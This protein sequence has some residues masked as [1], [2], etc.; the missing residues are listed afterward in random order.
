VIPADAKRNLLVTLAGRGASVGLNFMATV[1]VIRYLGPDRYGVY[2]LVVTIVTLLDQAAEVPLFEIAVREMAKSGERAPDWL[3]AVALVRGASGLA[4]GAALLAA[5]PL[6]G[7]DASMAAAAHAGALVF[8]ANAFRAPVTYFRSQLQIHWEL[9]LWAAARALEFGLVVLAS[10]AGL[11]VE[12]MIGAKALAAVAF[13][14][15]AWS[16]LLWRFRLSP[17]AG[18]GAVGPLCA[19]ALPVAVTA[20]LMLLQVKGDVLLI[21]F[22]LGPAAAGSFGAVAQIPEFVLV[23]NSVLS[24]TSGPLLARTLGRGDTGQFQALFQRLFDGLAAVLPGLATVACLAAGPCVSAVFGERYAAMVPEFRILVWVGAMIPIAGLMGTAA[25]ALDLQRRLVRVEAVNVLVYAAANLLLL[26]RVG[27]LASAWTRLAVVLIG[28]AWTYTTVR[29][30]TGYSLSS[31]VVLRAAAAAAA[32]G[33]VGAVLPVPSLPAAAAA[34]LVYV[35][36]Y[37]DASGLLFRTTRGLSS[38]AQTRGGERAA[39]G[40][41]EPFQ[42]NGSITPVG[43]GRDDVD[44]SRSERR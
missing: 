38:V 34:A 31:R 14:A 44:P 5:P 10:T 15:A 2:L 16:V 6:A 37:S 24:A 12:A 35:F 28:T 32:A 39:P 22:I 27:T 29:T 41:R 4:F 40:T 19:F 36:L 42:A 9:G 11:G 13:A 21:G 20:V 3:A 43:D 30:C 8:F 1:W 33:A 26:G 23:A 18:R 7:L 25:L 17:P